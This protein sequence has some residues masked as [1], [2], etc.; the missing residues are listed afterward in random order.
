MTLDHPGFTDPATESQACFRAVLDA[1]SRPGTVRPAGGALQPPA[2]LDPATAA[3]LLTLADADTL[4]WLDTATMP[5]WD[6]LAF[7]SGARRAATAGS[8]AFACALS[9][10]RLADLN[11]GGDETPEDSATLILQVPALD[12]GTAYR[13]SGPGLRTPALLSVAGLPQDF[14]AQ[15]AANAARYPLGVDVVLCAGR[16]LCALPRSVQIVAA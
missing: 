11:P 12:G 5:A 14:V 6:W 4:L 1:M 9:M 3:A 16:Q 8:A 2:P 7:H 10:P 13:L 15:W